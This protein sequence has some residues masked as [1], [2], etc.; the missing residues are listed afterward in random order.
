MWVRAWADPESRSTTVGVAAVIVYVLFVWLVGPRLFP[1]V[2]VVFTAP[3]VE[4]SK[5]F[6]IEMA[7]DAF[8][9]QPPPKPPEPFKFVEANPNAPDQAPDKTTNFSFMNQQVAQEKPTPNGK[10]DRPAME[11]KKDF[12]S[13]QIVTGQLSK[14]VEHV[15]A[16]PPSESQQEVV[17]KAPRPEIN[18]LSGFEKKQGDDANAYGSN[19][20]KIPATSSSLQQAQAGVKNAPMTDD[21]VADQPAIDPKKPRARPSIVTQQQVRPAI[22]AE[23]KFGTSNIGNIAVDAKWSSYG[24]YLQKMLET[25]QVQW[26]RILIESRTYPPSGTSVTVKFV[27]EGS[28][29]KIARIISVDGTAGDTGARTCVSGITDRAPYGAWTDDMKA[30]L[31]EKQ[32]MTF[33][34]YY[35]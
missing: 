20:A 14:P 8:I 16:T 27:L 19:I 5:Q 13:T 12:E 24:A 17:T 22:F 31:G 30:V 3:P 34:F 9:A 18:P 35:Q 6:S 25:V 32:E 33:T 21:A 11:G 2:P 10:S 1:T 28:E 23:N 7:P 4:A 26:E 15:E 29:G